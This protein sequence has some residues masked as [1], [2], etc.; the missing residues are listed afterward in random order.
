MSIRAELTEK[1]AILRKLPK[2]ANF[3]FVPSVLQSAVMEFVP[4]SWNIEWCNQLAI[5][6]S[7]DSQLADSEMCKCELLESKVCKWKLCAAL[8]ITEIRRN[9][10]ARL[11]SG[12]PGFFGSLADYI[13]GCV[14]SFWLSDGMPGITYHLGHSVQERNW[15]SAYC[16]VVNHR[17]IIASDLR[18]LSSRSIACE[19]GQVPMHCCGLQVDNI[20][21]S[22][23]SVEWID[24]MWEIT[25]LFRQGHWNLLH[26]SSQTL[27]A[28]KYTTVQLCTWA[29][30]IASR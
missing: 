15:A 1:W 27:K 16:T 9:R 7:R 18:N 12:A 24:S 26:S 11:C 19:I 6:I 4:T 30:R 8:S 17:L 23:K 25:H 14:K 3:W 28:G 5:G 10:S 29:L 22:E 13:L 2:S 21:W 20:M